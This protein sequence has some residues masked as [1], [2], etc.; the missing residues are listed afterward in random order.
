MSLVTLAIIKL[1]MNIKIGALC[2]GSMVP[3][4][5]RERNKR[6]KKVTKKTKKSQ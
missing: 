3:G 4:K 5:E 2:C 1:G 6:R